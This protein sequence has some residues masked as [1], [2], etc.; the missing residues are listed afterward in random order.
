MKFGF[1]NRLTA[2]YACC[3]WL[4]AREAPAASTTFAAAHVASE[5]VVRPPKEP[6]A[7][8]MFSRPF[9]SY[10]TDDAAVFPALNTKCVFAVVD[11]DVP[12]VRVGA[13]SESV[14]PVTWMSPP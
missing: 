7:A 13:V 3:M 1:P 4:R 9:D 6:D 5:A 12:N 14:T 2:L 11:T 8:T 10:D